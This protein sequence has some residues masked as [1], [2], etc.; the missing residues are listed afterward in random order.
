MENKLRENYSN[1][2]FYSSH[3]EILNLDKFKLDNNYVVFSGI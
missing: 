2:D 3:Y 1:L